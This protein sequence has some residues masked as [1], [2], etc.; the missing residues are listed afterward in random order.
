MVILDVSVPTLGRFFINDD[1][2]T[3]EVLLLP[4]TTDEEMKILEESMQRKDAPWLF[5]SEVLLASLAS[6]FNVDKEFVT[7]HLNN[8]PDPISEPEQ[9]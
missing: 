2:S 6:V 4:S 8:E 7:F 1:L 9:D 5:K 3:E